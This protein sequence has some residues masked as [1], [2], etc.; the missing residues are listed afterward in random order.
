[1]WCNMPRRVSLKANGD[2]LTKMIDEFKLIKG[3]TGNSNR[4]KRFKC[5]F[6]LARYMADFSV[7]AKLLEAAFR[8]FVEN[9]VENEKGF[10]KVFDKLLPKI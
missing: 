3:M 4:V 8:K 10:C 9:G 2:V 7:V 5:N 1:M 6:L